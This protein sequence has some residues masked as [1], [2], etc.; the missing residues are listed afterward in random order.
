M[1]KPVWLTRQRV[2]ITLLAVALIAPFTVFFGQGAPGTGE[3]AREFAR[4][5]RTCNDLGL[6]CRGECSPQ[7][8]ALF[9]PGIQFDECRSACVAACDLN[10]TNCKLACQFEFTGETPE[11]P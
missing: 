4:C 1:R 3:Q 5:N 2:L 7:C 8:S 10:K 9:P 6:A 11:L